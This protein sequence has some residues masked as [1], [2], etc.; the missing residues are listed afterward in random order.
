[1]LRNLLVL[2]SFFAFSAFAQGLARLSTNTPDTLEVVVFLVEFAKESPDNS[3]TTGTGSFG[4]DTDSRSASFSLD[5]QNRR[6]TAA[7]WLEHM[8]F[9]RHYFEA[10]SHGK[11]VI[12]SQVFPRNRTAYQLDKQIID[13]NRT[14]RQ[15]GETQAEYEEARVADYMA[16]VKDAILKADADPED[17]PFRLDSIESPNRKRVYLLVHAGASRLLDG[18]ELGS[19]NANTPGDFLDIFVSRDAWN[20]LPDSPSGLVLHGVSDTVKEMMVLSETASQDGVNWGVNGMLV[21]QIGQQL[22]W[23]LTYDIVKSLSRVG[24]FDVMDFAGY[25]TGNGFFPVLPSAWLRAYMGWSPVREMRPGSTLSQALS[26]AAA[27]SGLGNE[28]IKIPLTSNEYLL[29]ENRQRTLDGQVT[30]SF[31]DGSSK[32]VS[33]DSLSVLFLDS[34]CDA[35]G[36]CRIN[37]R[38]AKGVITEVSS[39]D[40]TLPGSGVAVWHVNDWHLRETLRYGAINYW[41]GDTLRDHQFGVALVEADGIPTLGKQF[42]NALGQ[43]VYDYGSGSDLFP[44]ARFGGNSKDTVDELSGDGYSNTSTTLGGLSGVRLIF[45]PAK[46][47]SV[48]KT[49]SVFTGDS[50][51]NWRSP[52]MGLKI[53]W[54]SQWI[55]GSHW[56]RKT[57]APFLTGMQITFAKPTGIS[58]SGSRFLVA[59]TED[60]SLHVYGVR[61]DTLTVADTL[62]S[63]SQKLDSTW[64]LL[65]TVYS[66]DSTD[67]LPVYR[68]GEPHAGILGTAALGDTLFAL[69]KDRL[70]AWRWTVTSGLLQPLASSLMLPSKSVAPPMVANGKVWIADSIS[71]LSAHKATSL[72]W[73]DVVNWPMGFQ[74]QQLSWCKDLDGDEIGEILVIGNTG[75]L[76]IYKSINKTFQIILPPSG[77]VSGIYRFATSDFDRDGKE[78]TFVLS[79]WGKGFWVN[80]TAGTSGGLLQYNRGQGLSQGDLSPIALGDINGDGAVDAVFHGYNRIYAVDGHGVALS[81]FP[82]RWTRGVSQN[83]LSE[84]PLLSDVDGSAGLEI[85]A[86]T[87]Q[88]LLYAFHGTTGKTLGNG[89]PRAVGSFAYSD[90]IQPVGLLIADADTSAGLEIITTHRNEWNAYSLAKT[91]VSSPS[92]WQAGGSSQRQNYL[93]ASLL[94]NLNENAIMN[95]I[96]E[97]FLFPNPIRGGKANVRFA[98]TTPA[99]SV[100]LHVYDLSSQK[101]QTISLG[102]FSSGRF[103][104]AIDFSKLGSDVYAV[105]IEVHFVTGVRKL[106]WD[107]IGIVK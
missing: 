75:A 27:G 45:A 70:F 71:L 50:V 91:V 85:L 53:E 89:W 87:P 3:L 74:P 94:S 19:S 22:G 8:D 31:A 2:I 14:A 11:L 97:F 92:W 106:A 57:P 9:A 36:S 81:G 64:T 18:G 62:V 105:S 38:K 61:G 101:V 69:F 76:L 98:L 32:T 73:V 86:A 35:Q 59:P 84:S 82:I 104:R 63:I 17:S 48:E 23:P 1:M 16:F 43:A 40:A 25:S 79:N 42:R 103:E 66:L 37:S 30:V 88:G 58:A 107:R 20:Y 52:L 26:I 13:Y 41:A 10:A 60:G 72:Q 7:Y 78:E 55:P 39:Y 77:T 54:N 34:L 15:S 95:A 99:K 28:I 12:E 49:S 33:I 51:R 100:Q 56:P 21:N 65:E 47:S 96:Q 67:S 5:P 90:T 83:G 44:H 68:L 29:L 80:L 93:D 102:E 46:G 24:A 4:S 6:G